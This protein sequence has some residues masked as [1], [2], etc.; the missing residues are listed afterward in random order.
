M[1]AYDGTRRAAADSDVGGGSVA[2]AFSYRVT[3]CRPL[4]RDAPRLALAELLLRER[5][6]E[7]SEG[8][9]GAAWTAHAIRLQL[10]DPCLE[11]RR[12]VLQVCHKL[13]VPQT[14]LPRRL[15]LARQPAE[16]MQRQT[17]G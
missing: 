12:L 10:R 3:N 5:A 13:L 16:R 15:R 4:G 8:D 9:G 2:A 11:R 17:R 14:G 6:L 1:L 7:F